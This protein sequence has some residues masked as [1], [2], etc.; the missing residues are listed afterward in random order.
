[1]IWGTGMFAEEVISQCDVFGL[2]DVVGFIDN[3]RK[4]R[5]QAF[6]G[7]KVFLPDVLRKVILDR[8]VIL[9]FHH[10]EIEEQIQREF[11]DI[12]AIVEG[13]YFF[14]KQSLMK[15]YRNSCDSEI[16]VILKYLEKHDLQTFN[17]DF[18]NKYEEMIFDIHF[19][20]MC[21]MYYV[22]HAGKKMYFAKSLKSREEV[23]KYY[24]SILMEQDEESPHKY[25]DGE[26]RVE[27]G[28]VVVDIGV[29][30]GNFSL[31]VIDRVSRLYIIE[32]DDGWIEALRE[33][34]R[35]YEDKVIIIK[36]Y[37]SSLDL[38]RYATLD[39]LIKEPV[40]FIKMDIEGNE[41][42]ALL[43]AERLISESD[44]LKCSIC[45]YH[46]D[47]DEILIKDQLK[48]YKMDVSVTSGYMWFSEMVKL[49][50]VSTKLC[51]GLVRGTKQKKGI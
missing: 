17:Y 1:M 12:S 24:R 16:N 29:A 33:T 44:K 47:C 13:M 41:W 15:R 48:K 10:E 11:P 51:R 30:E 45:A 42:D 19:D 5:G 40:N 38:G 46:A 8:I 20:Q 23:A 31:Q 36:K 35:E 27:K 18:T 28:D 7:K 43:G 37:I 14:Y 25:V 9:T 26:F 49:T 21:S 39:S 22:Y 34:F 2:Y 50:H 6:H 4:K 3:N 32:A